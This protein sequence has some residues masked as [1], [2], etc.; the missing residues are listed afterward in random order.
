MPRILLAEDD[1]MLRDVMKDIFQSESYEVLTARDGSEALKL[2]ED[3]YPDLIV[4][5]ISMPGM[6]GFSLLAAI[7]ERPLGATIPF[8]FTSALTER[9]NVNRARRLG[10]DDYLFKPFDSRELLDAVD[11]R[12]ARRKAVLLADTHEAHL[13]TVCM[14][15]NVIEA[16]DIYTRGHVERVK[17][18]ALAL[19]RALDWDTDDLKILE[20]GA[21]LHDI[22][23]IVIP[24][25]V[26]NN[27]GHLDGK[28]WDLMRRH[29][30]VGADMLRNISHLQ[31]AIPY[32]LYHH[33][34]WD[35]SGYPHGL[36]GEG[37]PLEGRLLAVV[38]VFDALT[39]ER[40]YHQI[41]LK[42]DA[43]Q[44]IRS[45]SNSH[46]DPYLVDVFVKVA[47]DL[48]SNG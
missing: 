35:G 30:I 10:M 47:P 19:G 1:D 31:A 41:M 27:S 2:I 6:D 8:L 14:L 29:P 33:E 37:I 25:E 44:H 18:Y 42:E 20:Y 5:D 3:F 7:R 45:G 22:G 17:N 11:V 26:L 40:S 21:I 48:F 9:S 23:K 38:D 32:V 15:A 13:Q 28:D 46:F 34:R 12:L 4:S 16:R 24:V 39:T 43:L 36:A